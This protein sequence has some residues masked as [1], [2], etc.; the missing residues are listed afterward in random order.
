[1]IKP[2]T[3]TAEVQEANGAGPAY[4]AITNAR[5]STSD[6]YN[7]GTSNPL[8]IPAAGLTLSYWKSIC[9]QFTGTFTSIDNIRHYCDGSLVWALGT[10]GGMVRGNRDAGD[11][12]CPPGSYDQATGTPGTTGDDVET[13]SFYSGQTT[14]SADLESDVAPNG[15]TIDSNAYTSADDRCYFVVLQ[16]IVDTDATQGTLATETFTWK[17]DEI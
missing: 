13:H 14:K 6:V 4:N 3:A 7:P 1:M 11:H 12:G 15:A 16:M 8:P 2:L 9:L 17:Y 5:F 10:S